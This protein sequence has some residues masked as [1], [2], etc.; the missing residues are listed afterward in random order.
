MYLELAHFACVN[1]RKG[2]CELQAERDYEKA[3]NIV[4]PA[5]RDGDLFSYCEQSVKYAYF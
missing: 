1:I 3:V 2:D 4:L 5:L